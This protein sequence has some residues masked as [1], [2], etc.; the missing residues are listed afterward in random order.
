LRDTVGGAS[1]PDSVV[2]HRFFRSIAPT[3]TVVHAKRFNMV[4]HSTGRNPM[5]DQKAVSSADQRANIGRPRFGVFNAIVLQ[6]AAQG[7]ANSSS[8]MIC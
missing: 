8:R 2:R 7:V 6:P 4:K 5:R 1:I 3:Q